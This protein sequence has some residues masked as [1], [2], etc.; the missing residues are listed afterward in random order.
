MRLAELRDLCVDRG[1]DSNG[2]K[3]QL[4]QR[5]REDDFD[6]DNG[7]I[8]TDN[9]SNEDNISNTLMQTASFLCALLVIR[10][11]FFLSPFELGHVFLQHVFLTLFSRCSVYE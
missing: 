7:A 4:L 5:L 1:L 10:N 11:S 8:G 6:K 2:N 9:T 3:S